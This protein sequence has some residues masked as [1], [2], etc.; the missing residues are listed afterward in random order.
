MTEFSQQRIQFSVERALLNADTPYVVD[1]CESALNSLD[2]NNQIAFLDSFTGALL[3]R[4]HID[5]YATDYLIRRFELPENIDQFAEHP[6][7]HRNLTALLQRYREQLGLDANAPFPLTGS[8]TRLQQTRRR[9]LVFSAI[10][11]AVMLTVAIVMNFLDRP[12]RP[13]DKIGFS[14]F[15]KDSI[16]SIVQTNKAFA[17]GS[18]VTLS[19]GQKVWVTDNRTA[20]RD[21]ETLLIVN[22][23]FRHLSSKD[24]AKVQSAV[25]AIHSQQHQ[26]SLSEAI[27]GGH[28]WGFYTQ[29]VKALRQ[30]LVKIELPSDAY[31]YV[32]QQPEKARDTLRKRQAFVEKSL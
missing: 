24:F 23:Q 11:I 5:Q 13:T 25:E 21:D 14:R 12:T 28:H 6:A 7:L 9:T 1:A 8:D 10:I 19:L 22:F 16:V 31:F 27:F 30:A 32:S 3:R 15:H 20:A 2:G 18:L 29:D 26:L 17:N 4:D